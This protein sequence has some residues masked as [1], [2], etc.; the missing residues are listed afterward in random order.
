M[1][2]KHLST[3]EFNI[4]DIK[5]ISSKSNQT[6]NISDASFNYEFC[7]WSYFGVLGLF[8]T[9]INFSV[10]IR[11]EESQVKTSEGYIFMKMVIKQQQTEC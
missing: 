3:S 9:I 10:P 11:D 6:G 5:S 7:Q 1:T 2:L 8:S 4:P